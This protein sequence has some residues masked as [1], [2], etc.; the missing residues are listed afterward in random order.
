MPVNAGMDG[1]AYEIDK[2]LEYLG[3]EEALKLVVEKVPLLEP[4]EIPLEMCTGRIAAEDMAAKV[5]Y[6]SQDVSQKDGYAVV[7]TDITRASPDSPV[8]LRV[9]GSAYAGSS[10]A[11]ANSLICIPEGVKRLNAGQTIAVRVL[12]PR[13]DEMQTR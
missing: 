7:P 11:G 9:T 12:A 10:P 8:R 1:N 2:G 13:I 5:R 3:Y 6:P 4:G